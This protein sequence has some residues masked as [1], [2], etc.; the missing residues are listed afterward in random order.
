M[1]ERD[2]G[3]GIDLGTSNSSVCLLDTSRGT[4]DFATVRGDGGLTEIPS[5][6]ARQYGQ[7]YFGPAAIRRES[8]DPSVV[9]RNFKLLLRSN[10]PVAIGEEEFEP[11]ELAH[12][13]LSY[14]KTGYEHSFGHPIRRAVITVPAYEEFDVDY[15][16]RIR[17]A[18]VG[19]ADGE[20]LFDDVVTLKE[21]DAV[22]MSLIELD[23]LIDKTVLVFDMGGGTLDVTIRKVLRNPDAPDRPIL[24][25]VSIFGSDMA[26]VRLTESLGDYVLS[27][28]ETRN[29]F[30]FSEQERQRA[31][32]LNFG[33]LDDVKR[34]LSAYGAV[35][36]MNSSRLELCHLEFPGKGQ[37]Y[38]DLELPAAVLTEV[39]RPLCDAALDTVQIA[40]TE[41]G[42][43][44]S[45]IDAYF[46]VGGTSQLPY[47]QHLLREYFGKAPT[48]RLSEHGL[49]DPYLAVS[50][51]A[52]A[53][54]LSREDVAHSVPNTAP[55]LEQVLPY[56]ISLLVNGHSELKVLVASKTSLPAPVFEQVFYM[57]QDSDNLDIHLYRG[58]G[59]VQDAAS[60]ACRTV[61]FPTVR[62]R[63]AE[64]KIR[65]AVNLDGSMD[66]EAAGDDGGTITAFTTSTI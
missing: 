31:L 26:G 34:Q 57:P 1:A 21:P 65:I 48:P 16:T 58:S 41:A 51:G 38:F 36:G 50:K 20:P 60:L 64:V 9:L 33:R 39:S 5:A 56:D 13:F 30:A 4:Y 12:R 15:Q 59:S 32:R 52:A 49:V 53:Y 37:G 7:F 17:A 29:R 62:Q 45:D 14:L 28:W 42:L 22:L 63:N 6:V 19:P 66:V 10:I 11:V 18:V 23:Q 2:R 47:M 55:V 27:Q 25:P 35:D 54:D 8:A 44:P 46:A 61:F 24:R 3:V 40:L 43:M